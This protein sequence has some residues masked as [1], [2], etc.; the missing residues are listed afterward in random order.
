MNSLASVQDY[1]NNGFNSLTNWNADSLFFGG[2]DLKNRRTAKEIYEGWHPGVFATDYE[3]KNQDSQVF[4]EDKNGNYPPWLHGA[5]MSLW[6]SWAPW[7]W[8]AI[9]R[10]LMSFAQKCWNG[11][12]NITSWNKFKNLCDTLAR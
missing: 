2:N 8:G 1:L 12:K 6:W 11:S 7:V 3:T 4:N 10:P 9:E 5:D